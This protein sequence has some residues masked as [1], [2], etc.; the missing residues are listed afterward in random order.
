MSENLLIKLVSIPVEIAD[1][2]QLK[3]GKIMI[4][5]ITGL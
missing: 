3:T 1:D 4:T 5:I 2:H